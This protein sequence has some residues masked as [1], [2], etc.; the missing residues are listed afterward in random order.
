METKLQE[1]PLGTPGSRHLQ[2]P[3]ALGG[4]LSSAVR[5]QSV[6]STLSSRNKTTK[7]SRKPEQYDRCAS[8]ELL[9]KS[10][11][12]FW[13]RKPSSYKLIIWRHMSLLEIPNKPLFRFSSRGR[14]KFFEDEKRRAKLFY[15]MRPVQSSRANPVIRFRFT[16]KKERYCK[17]GEVLWP[18]MAKMHHEKVLKSAPVRVVKMLTTSS[19]KYRSNLVRF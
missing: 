18:R 8:N 6:L 14:R 7:T 15:P 9:L 11:R 5:A 10:L 2:R 13:R 16:W 4:S 12:Y 1:L 3:E 17:I 19:Y